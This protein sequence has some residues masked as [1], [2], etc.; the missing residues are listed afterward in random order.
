MLTLAGV[1]LPIKGRVLLDGEDLQKPDEKDWQKTRT[2]VAFVMSS[3]TLVSHLTIAQNLMLPLTY[4]GVADPQQAE[5]SALEMMAWITHILRFETPLN[6]LPAQLNER[7]RK[8]VSLGRA[9]ILQPRVL[10]VDHAFSNLDATMRGR[11]IE[12]YVS[13]AQKRNVALVLASK[14][15]KVLEQL[16][17]QCQRIEQFIFLAKN[18]I[19]CFNDWQSLI[20]SEI[21][22]LQAFKALHAVV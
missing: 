20:D 19:L 14:E 10:F 3:Q 16:Q 17:T 15:L 11:F 2:D 21:A 5:Q 22:E 12:L 18:D 8:A 13:I 9:L 1:D 4:H 7:Q 6:C